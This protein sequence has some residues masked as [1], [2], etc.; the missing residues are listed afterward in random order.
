VPTQGV[1]LRAPALQC[2]S[3]PPL[4]G[5]E[6]SVDQLPDRAVYSVLVEVVP[7]VPRREDNISVIVPVEFADQRY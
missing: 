4:D 2:E 7:K 3:G 1:F 5:N 6:A